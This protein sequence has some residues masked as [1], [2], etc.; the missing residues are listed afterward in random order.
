MIKLYISGSRHGREGIY[1]LIAETGET[2]AGHYCSDKSFALGDLVSKRPNGQNEW[3]KK[4]GEYKVLFLG[5][6][7]MTRDKLFA[8]NKIW[9]KNEKNKVL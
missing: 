8:L 4:F 6:D 3:R 9:C 7:E 5:E 2:L 1:Y